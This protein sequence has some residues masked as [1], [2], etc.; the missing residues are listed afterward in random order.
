MFSGRAVP[1]WAPSICLGV[2]MVVLLQE[3][4]RQSGHGFFERRIQVRIGG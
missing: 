1:V 4:R 3:S 2:S